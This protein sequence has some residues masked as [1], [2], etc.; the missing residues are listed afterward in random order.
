M[1]KVALFLANG[2]EEIEALATV[3]ILRR[4]QIPVETVSILNE[5]T[6]TGAHNVSVIADKIFQEA[7]FSDIEVLVLPGGMPGAKHLNEYEALKELIIKFND[8]GKQIAA[9]CAAPIV[10]G[11]LGLLNDKRATCYPGFEAELTGAKT[12]GENVVVDGNIT[13]GRGPGLVFDF[14]LRL[15][16]QIAGLKTRQ[17]VQN[18]LLL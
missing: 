11:G 13:T 8:E 18:G 5:K 10:L 2:F 16:E 3:D 17:E 4:A 9:I 7:D 15:V 1:K 12:I 14:A 6:V